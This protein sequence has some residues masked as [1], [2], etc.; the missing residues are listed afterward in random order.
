MPAANVR[1]NPPSGT[2]S[3]TRRLLAPVF[4]ALGLWLFLATASLARC[5]YAAALAGVHDAYRAMLVERGQERILAATTLL[6]LLGRDE[7]SEFA[8]RLARAGFDVSEE[9]LSPALR[10]GG[11]LARYVLAGGVPPPG[12]GQHSA[13][14]DFLADTY[15]ATGCRSV[16]PAGGRPSDA[17]LPPAPHETVRTSRQRA[18]A[19]RDIAEV[20]LHAAIGLSA[21]VLAGVGGHRVLTSRYVRKSKVERQPRKPVSIEVGVSFQ[22]EKQISRVNVR[23]IDISV[24]GMKV[25]WKDPPEAGRKV[26]VTMPMG[27]RGGAV[28]WSNAFYAGIMFDDF[29]TESEL[30]D[31]SAAK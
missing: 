9:R 23:V 31:L 27:D 10:D 18:D 20:S 3:M 6:V 25:E 17:P 22:H 4:L 13:N 24:G 21:L 1:R 30:K 12:L 5:E 26:R 16:I 28:M 8:G 2:A 14:V 7:G 15:V 11:T 29:L 19:P